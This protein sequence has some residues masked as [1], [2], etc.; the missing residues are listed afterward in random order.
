MRSYLGYIYIF[1]AALCWGLIGPVARFSFAAGIS[2]V[3]VAFWRACFGGVFFA[4]HAAALHS[5]TINAP[6]DALVFA[7]FGAVSLG[8]FFACNQY[9]IQTGGAALAAV[10]LYTAP[11]WVAM[12]SRMFFGE[13]LTLGKLTAIGMSLAGV[14]CISFSGGEAPN[15]DTA[16]LA[17]QAM[18]WVGICFGLLSGLLYSTHYIFS[19]HYLKRYTTHTLYGYCMLFGALALLPGVHFAH[20]GP[21]DW[22]VLLCLGFVSTYGAYI[23]YCAGMRRLAPTRAAVLATLEPAVATFT[24]WWL[25]DERFTVVGWLGAALIIAAVLCLVAR[26]VES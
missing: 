10:L 4:I 19:A 14:A 11:A 25:W 7:L 8:G 1:L 23:F 15:A 21:A 17:H 3:E 12:F 22:L 16:P 5:F 18:N 9:A 20:K 6:R 2:P 24:A 26:P 13:R